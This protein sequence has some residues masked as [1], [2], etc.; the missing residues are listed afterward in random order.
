MWNSLELQS[1][2]AVKTLHLEMAICAHEPND[3]CFGKRGLA[4]LVSLLP[5]CVES[6]S[7]VI[8]QPTA[9]EEARQRIRTVPEWGILAD[10]LRKIST[11]RSVTIDIPHAAPDM[12]YDDDPEDDPGFYAW[13]RQLKDLLK[14][15]EGMFR[16]PS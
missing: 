14:P 2:Q 8:T 7:I 16:S 1:C 15:I 4:L 9:P 5:R 11:M 6:I 3:M 10:D 12:A 13:N